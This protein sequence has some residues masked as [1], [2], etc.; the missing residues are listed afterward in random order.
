MLKSSP[1]WTKSRQSQGL[2]CGINFGDFPADTMVW[3]VFD[4]FGPGMNGKI[5]R[6]Q[7]EVRGESLFAARTNAIRA[8]P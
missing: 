2:G 6:N 7:Q 8:P 4:R 1:G 3:T 5:D